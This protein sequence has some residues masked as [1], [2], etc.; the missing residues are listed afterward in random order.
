MHLT[1]RMAWHDSDW[2]GLHGP[3]STVVRRRLIMEAMHASAPELTGLR[4]KQFK[5]AVNSVIETAIAACV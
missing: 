1:V 4:A 2:N 3:G 5:D